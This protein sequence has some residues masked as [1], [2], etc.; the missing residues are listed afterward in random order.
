M[1][2]NSKALITRTSPK[3]ATNLHTGAILS[4][5]SWGPLCVWCLPQFTHSSLH[6]LIPGWG[7]W[8]ANRVLVTY[9]FRFVTK[10]GSI[11]RCHATFRSWARDACRKQP[12]RQGQLRLGDDRERLPAMGSQLRT[13]SCLR[14]SGFCYNP[15]ATACLLFHM[16]HVCFV[17][18]VF[19]RYTYIYIYTS[20]SLSLSLP[21][22]F[23]YFCF[24]YLC[25][26]EIR[27]SFCTHL[28]H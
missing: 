10:L 23:R 7:E 15:S 5:S 4:I 24:S 19:A 8:F 17:S 25:M 18:P 20:L 22:S 9:Q 27:I 16:S 3:R 2:Q 6:L 26:L 28:V 13:G 1:N 11:W 14:F 21:L 12:A